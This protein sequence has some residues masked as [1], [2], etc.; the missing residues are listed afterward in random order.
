MQVIF[1][2][3][4]VYANGYTLLMSHTVYGLLTRKKI[5]VHQSVSFYFQI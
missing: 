4:N 5:Q 3:F 2:Y 1:M